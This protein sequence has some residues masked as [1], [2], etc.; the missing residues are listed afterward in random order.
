MSAFSWLDRTLEI[1][2]ES[3]LQRNSLAVWTLQMWWAYHWGNSLHAWRDI[4]HL[5]C[6]VQ[7]LG[8]HSR[9]CWRLLHKNLEPRSRTC[10]FSTIHLFLQ[11]QGCPFPTK[12]YR[13]FLLLVASAVPS[14]GRR[15]VCGI[16]T[17]TVFPVEIITRSIGKRLVSLLLL[18]SFSP[19]ALGGRC[20]TYPTLD[21]IWK[22]CACL[23]SL[24]I[25][26]LA[27]IFL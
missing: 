11:H 6:P 26:L 9:Q 2:N 3:G 14:V 18:A 27:T 1:C 5:R 25:G 24:P 12:A 21:C 22:G 19:A 23:G 16:M 20:D 8:Y 15:L 13:F 17:W 10:Q 4:F 7:T